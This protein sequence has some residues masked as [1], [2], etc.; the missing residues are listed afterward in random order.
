MAGPNSLSAHEITAAAKKSVD[1]V[2]ADHKLRPPPGFPLG[3]VRPPWWWIGIIIRTQGLTT[4]EQAESLAKDLHGS[5]AAAVP[6]AKAG[7]P[8]ALI[9]GGHLTIGFVPPEPINL[10]EG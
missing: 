5:I 7:T 2:L 1:K 8:S 9:Q 6:S 4:L 3:F 10:L